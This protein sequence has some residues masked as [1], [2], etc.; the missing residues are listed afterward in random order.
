MVAAL[1]MSWLKVLAPF[2]SFDF[3]ALA[4]TLV[5]GFPM[6]EEAYGAVRERRMTMELS[7]TIAVVATLIIGQFF[8]GL[9]I[10]FF[11]IFAELLE[12]LTV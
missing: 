3:I 6:F 1:V 10:T 8:T 12:H 9:V 2:T 11:V 5:G 4:A 7:M